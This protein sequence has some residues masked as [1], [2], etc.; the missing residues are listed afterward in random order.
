MAR[1]CASS[2]SVQRERRLASGNA[3]SAP[4]LIRPPTTGDAE[5]IAELLG[6]LGYPATPAEV[7]ARLERLTKLES[8]VIFVAEADGRAVGVV[9]GHLFPAIHANA[10]VAW[11]TTLV[12]GERYQHRGIGAQLTAVIE[13]WARANGAV[14]VSLTS[15]FQRKEA[16]AFYEHLGYE[17][18]GLRLTKPL[19][20]P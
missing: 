1:R 17:R 3:A 9:T 2:P 4:A 14:R 8:A 18:T 10:T 11:L 19:N 16:H 13:D 15:G 12:V 5:S 7:L 6:V 20:T